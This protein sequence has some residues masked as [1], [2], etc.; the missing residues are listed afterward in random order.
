[1]TST[2]PIQLLFFGPLEFLGRQQ[3]RLT[4]RITFRGLL[5]LIFVAWYL[6]LT[7]IPGWLSLGA[8]WK[9]GFGFG[10]VI[11]AG[12][13]VVV[14][15]RWDEE[16]RAALRG[17]LEGDGDYIIAT[18]F[19]KLDDPLLEIKEK[20]GLSASQ[21]SFW[22]LVAG[23]MGMI[24]GFARIC[25][26]VYSGGNLAWF[27]VPQQVDPSAILPWIWFGSINAFNAIDIFDFL[28]VYGISRISLFGWLV[29]EPIHQ[30]GLYAS[31]MV[32]A[33]RLVFD[34]MLL[35]KLKTSV[36]SLFSYLAVVKKTL[37]IPQGNR[38]VYQ[39][40]KLGEVLRE[41]GPFFIR[42]YAKRFLQRKAPFVGSF[43]WMV[44]GW[45]WFPLKHRFHPDRGS[46][47]E[48]RSLEVRLFAAEIL[49]Y[50]GVESR[51]YAEDVVDL[52]EKVKVSSLA[53]PDAHKPEDNPVLR[54]MSALGRVEATL[55]D[56]PARRPNWLQKLW[57]WFLSIFGGNRT[58][59]NHRPP[60]LPD[61]GL[62]GSWIAPSSKIEF[63][64]IP[65]GSFQMGSET[66]DIYRQ[67]GDESD[68][69]K[70]EP[71]RKVELT[72][73]YYLSRF[74][75]TQEQFGR[76]AGY[77]PSRFDENVLRRL[78]GE[79]ASKTAG[80]HPVEQVSWL[81]AQAFCLWLTVI[82]R[83]S[84]RLPNGWSF[85]LPTEAQWEYACKGS[86][87][88]FLH[89]EIELDA[90]AWHEG[91]SKKRTWPVGDK[92]ANDFGL[93]DMLGNVFE[94]TSDWFEAEPQ[95]DA[96]VN[97]SGPTVGE[98]RTD[99]G[100]CWRSERDSCRPGNRYGILPEYRVYDLGFRVALVRT[101]ENKDS[102]N[103][104]M[105]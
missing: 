57:C 53:T 74:P 30:R 41:A 10:V 104:T 1:M 55:A 96:K 7:A 87:E 25:Q 93:Y 48:L 68:V 92:S 8:P 13:L 99:K 83:K 73:P 51:R 98:G 26:G 91:N 31:G 75:V 47:S 34:L 11:L 89:Q 3:L 62:R 69:A 50:S 9:I 44:F 54:L 105:E 81:E 90:M 28:T 37:Q 67:Y 94:W 45:W 80:R 5:S 101:E 42:C 65:K 72:R 60:N 85:C 78:A 88:V 103:S 63:V 19:G 33:F 16:K 43:R 15:F 76:I 23:G 95:P 46:Q 52:L 66:S 6:F 18:P 56:V 97:P 2:N 64:G 22:T 29:I 38:R 77:N 20:P 27:D 71:S 14:C 40:R 49:L 82:E 59:R 4:R 21:L 100:G 84:G 58:G 102:S 32:M 39:T 36:G 35:A 24:F 17:I 79:N 12:G 70:K 61:P 86:A